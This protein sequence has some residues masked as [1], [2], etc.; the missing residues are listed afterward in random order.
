MIRD[1]QRT[2]EEW[3]YAY[4]S[5][6]H[7]T[8]THYMVTFWGRIYDRLH[9]K[10]TQAGTNG[11]KICLQVLKKALSWHLENTESKKEK[12]DITHALKEI[13]TYAD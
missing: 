6:F 11:R 2:P 7:G 3:A 8:R 5:T 9:P 12:N 1:R 10:R 4:D 13:N